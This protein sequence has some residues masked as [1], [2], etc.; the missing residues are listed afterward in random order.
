MPS[1]PHQSTGSISPTG[2]TASPDGPSVVLLHG[3]PGSGDT[4]EAMMALLPKTHRL[5]APDYPGFGSSASLPTPATF[6]A[7]AEHVDALLRHLAVHRFTLYMFDF[8]GPVG[9]RLVTQDPSRITGLVFQNANIYV[10]GLG[11]A[12][13]GLKSYWTDPDGMRPRLRSALL[14]PEGIRGQ[15]HAGAVTPNSISSDAVRLATSQMKDPARQEAVLDLLLDYQHNLE[16]YGTWQRQIRAVD[17]PV[18]A[19]W[20]ERDPIFTIAGATGLSRDARR[21]TTVTL[22]AGHFAALEQ[23]AAV[24]EAVTRLLTREMTNPKS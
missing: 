22:P 10:E 2:T 3:F 11:P 4:F 18:L 15:H 14:S 17:I 9:M 12:F 19:V 21:L 24:A 16:F 1:R 8:G 13:A 20:G 5:I 6:Q 7:L 23:P